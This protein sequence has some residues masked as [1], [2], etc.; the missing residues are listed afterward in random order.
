VPDLAVY[1]GD[2]R[3]PIEDQVREAVADGRNVIRVVLTPESG[4]MLVTA[5]AR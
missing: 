1:R 3:G 2:S 4:D 5:F